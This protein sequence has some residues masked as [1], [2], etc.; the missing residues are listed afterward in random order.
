M[1]IPWWL[2][3]ILIFGLTGFGLLFGAY[4]GLHV[5]SYVSRLPGINIPE[6]LQIALYPLSA[7]VGVS[8]PQLAFR[9]WIH[10]ACPED[11]EAMVYERIRVYPDGYRRTGTLV[12]RYRCKKCGLT[13]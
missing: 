6:A 3:R 2:H 8:I 4:V 11:G 7:I 13:K 12:S 10:G 5:V 9:K 1:R